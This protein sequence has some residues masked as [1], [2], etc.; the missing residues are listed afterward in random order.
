MLPASLPLAAAKAEHMA[1]LRSAEAEI[2]AITSRA[3][4]EAARRLQSDASSHAATLAA[5]QAEDAAL[6]GRVE[7]LAAA[8]REKRVEA[9]IGGERRR[10]LVAEVEQL[11]QVRWM[12]GGGGGRMRGVLHGRDLSPPRCSLWRLAR[13]LTRSGL[14]LCR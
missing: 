12:M 1:A 5:L 6:R 14:P 11:K 9:Q 2:G 8:V 7:G 10:A 4:A 3:A 13:L